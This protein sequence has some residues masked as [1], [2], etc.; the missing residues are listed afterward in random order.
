MQ[1]GYGGS[2]Q[3]A[4]QGLDLAAA[5]ERRLTRCTFGRQ[6]DPGNPERVQFRTQLLGA[7]VEVGGDE[8]TVD[9]LLSNQEGCAGDTDDMHGRARFNQARAQVSDIWRFADNQDRGAWES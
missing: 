6:E 7:V 5:H 3:L 2:P 8:R 1:V 4:A 9:L